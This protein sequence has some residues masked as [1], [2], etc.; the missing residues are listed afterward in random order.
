MQSGRRAWNVIKSCRED[1]YPVSTALAHPQQLRG[2]ATKTPLLNSCTAVL[3]GAVS[4]FPG[5][6]KVALPVEALSELSPRAAAAEGCV[7]ELELNSAMMDGSAERVEEL[8]KF[9]LKLPSTNDVVKVEYKTECLQCAPL[10]AAIQGPATE[11]W[12]TH[13]YHLRHKCTLTDSTVRPSSSRHTLTGPEHLWTGPD[14]KTA[15]LLV[16]W[17]ANVKND[18]LLE[19]R[20]WEGDPSKQLHMVP[21]LHLAA[22][23]GNIKVL[24]FLLDEKACID[25]RSHFNGGNYHLCG[26][27]HPRSLGSM[28]SGS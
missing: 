7:D 14:F 6:G 10:C 17:K 13:R 23:T 20:A 8:L 15:T 26:S 2:S 27:H 9:G 11:A 21:P 16:D 4:A 3:P 24:D 5:D 28:G 1:G 19:E 25:Q 12:Q 22:G 18:Y